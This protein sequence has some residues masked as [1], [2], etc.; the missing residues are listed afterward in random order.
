MV[1]KG[2]TI[3]MNKRKNCKGKATCWAYCVTVALGGTISSK[4]ER[5]NSLVQSS[6]NTPGSMEKKQLLTSRTRAGVVTETEREA[7]LKF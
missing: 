7:V 2:N 1:L 4:K 6:K 5:N 3:N